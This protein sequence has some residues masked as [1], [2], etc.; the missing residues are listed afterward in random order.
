MKRKTKFN[1]T[2]MRCNKPYRTWGKYSKVCDDCKLP[3]ALNRIKKNEI[4]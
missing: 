2:C 1:R 4:K 3:N